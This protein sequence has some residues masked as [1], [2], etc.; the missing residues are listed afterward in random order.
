MKVLSLAFTVVLSTLMLES[1]Q[2]DDFMVD[3]ASQNNG[4]QAKII[5][6]NNSNSN[7]N[8]NSDSAIVDIPNVGTVKEVSDG[9]DEADSGDDSKSKD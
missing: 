3:F 6:S 2:K 1:C 9:D 7:T 5:G 4:P 8:T